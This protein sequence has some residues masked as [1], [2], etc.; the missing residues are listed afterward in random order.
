M[1]KKQICVLIMTLACTHHAF[2]YD[3]KQLERDFHDI[4]NL[5][6]RVYKSSIKASRVMSKA[7]TEEGKPTTTFEPKELQDVQQ[8]LNQESKEELLVQVGEVSP[9]KLAEKMPLSQLH[10]NTMILDVGKRRSAH[11][12]QKAV[13]PIRAKSKATLKRHEIIL[14]SLKNVKANPI[15]LEKES[16]RFRMQCISFC[17]KVSKRGET[18]AR[19][20]FNELL[21]RKEY[22]QQRWYFAGIVGIITGHPKLAREKSVRNLKTLLPVLRKESAQNADLIDWDFSVA[23]KEVPPAHKPPSNELTSKFSARMMS[24][25]KKANPFKQH[26]NTLK[27]DYWAETW[28]HMWGDM[29][30]HLQSNFDKGTEYGEQAGSF[31]GMAS[32]IQSSYGAMAANRTARNIADE[33]AK[34]AHETVLGELGITPDPYSAVG[35]FAGGVIGAVGGSIGNAAGWIYGTIESHLAQRGKSKAGIRQKTGGPS[36]KIK[37]F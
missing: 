27:P 20:K 12:S 37:L 4:A 14:A 5:G 28:Q 10:G 17:T 25:T 24:R 7:L 16:V 1:T 2:A 21:N 32:G 23:V 26:E 15:S 34:Y 11:R 19:I 18:A 22:A 6:D 30:D 8:E 13:P 35:H 29:A 3:T 9:D 33:V 36:T 31:I